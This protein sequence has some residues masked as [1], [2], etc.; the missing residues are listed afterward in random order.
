MATSD[1]P[2]HLDSLSVE[3]STALGRAVWIFSA[4]ES[5]TYDYLKQL[6]KEPLHELMADQLFKA[7]VKLATQLVAR[8]E[9]F[10]EEKAQALL[11]LKRAE[12][13]AKTRNAIAHNPW[14]IWADF[15]ARELKAAIFQRKEG[16]PVHT[17]ESVRQFTSEAEEVSE[18]LQS[19]LRALP[20][21]C[22]GA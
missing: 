13:L 7:R 3:I 16:A 17:L 14:R 20:Y 11:Y 22:N 6:S 15:E 8:I 10:S 2:A 12:N 1:P 5:A 4:I 18:G 9:G 21:V 19:S